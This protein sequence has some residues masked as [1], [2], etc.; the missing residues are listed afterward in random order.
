[1]KWNV[2]RVATKED[3]AK[4]S[5]NTI[6]EYRGILDGIIPQKVIIVDRTEFRDNRDIVARV[7]SFH[8]NYA[9]ETYDAHAYAFEDTYDPKTNTVTIITRKTPDEYTEKEAAR[10]A[11]YNRWID[12]GFSDM[13]ARQRLDWTLEMVR[14]Q[15]ECTTVN[16]ARKLLQNVIDNWQG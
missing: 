2:I 3:S 14:E 12:A 6:S 8:E 5:R 7:T 10:M 11:R 15:L 1:M 13:V 4:W 16:D 9:P